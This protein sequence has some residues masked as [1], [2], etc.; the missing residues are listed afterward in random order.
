MRRKRALFQWFSSILICLASSL[1]CKHLIETDSEQK[2]ARAGL[3]ESG[4]QVAAHTVSIIDPDPN[5]G[6]YCSGII[7]AK[8]LV[9]TAAHCFNDPKR[10]A[11]IL[12]NTFYNAHL[13]P[14]QQSLFKVRRVAIHA[15]YSQEQSD[16]YDKSIR[17]ANKIE[18][19]LNPGKP[20][21]DLALAYIEDKIP[22]GYEPAMIA[23]RSTDLT[24]GKITTAGYGCTTTL[25][26]DKNNALHKSTLR[27]VKIFAEAQMVLMSANGKR[28]SCTGDS[29]GPDFIDQG[30][31]LK[32]FAMVST[33]PASCEAGISVDTLIAP[34][35]EWID[36]AMRGARSG[37][38]SKQFRLLDY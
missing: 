33:G 36:Q 23:D 15:K 35:R 37:R 27:F 21:D 25:C 5:I 3:V 31:S 14:K 20:L 22:E 6:Q 8:D 38:K 11:Y 29:G 16:A 18:Q 30:T 12:F 24:S 17:E 19:V 32:V 4:D 28:G 34:Y 10:K 2:L 7:L 9:L 26:R 1:A 13:D